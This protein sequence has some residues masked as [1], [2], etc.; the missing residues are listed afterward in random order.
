MAALTAVLTAAVLGLVRAA[1]QS[2]P[3]TPPTAAGH[4]PRVGVHALQERQFGAA[5]A[6]APATVRMTPM[7]T[8]T[9]ASGS[10]TPAVVGGPAREVLGFAP[11][12]D[13]ANWR[14]WQ[15]SRL[16]TIA[17]FGVTLDGNGNPVHDEGWTAWQGQQLTD[18]VSAAHAAGVRVLVTVKCFDQA[19]IASI[20]SVP[21]H[22]RT[23][24]ATAL[25]L[26]RQRGLDG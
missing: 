1:G 7:Q 9:P 10:V 3:A 15:L 23:A 11:Y 14:R 18:M 5:A 25:A 19:S 2:A 24:V 13:M 4:D 16:S 8:T 22:A 20:V 12:W 21:T 17:Y 6:A 26:A